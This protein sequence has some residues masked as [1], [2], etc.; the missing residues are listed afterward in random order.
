MPQDAEI[1]TT[2]GNGNIADPAVDDGGGDYRVVYL[3][4]GGILLA[5]LL[6]FILLVVSSM[7]D[8][9]D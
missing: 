5:F 8:W 1:P 3:V 4:V 7:A 6:G 2:N 9:Q